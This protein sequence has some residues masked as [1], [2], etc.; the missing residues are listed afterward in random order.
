MSK[1]CL[2]ILAT[3]V[4][5][6]QMGCTTPNQ[7]RLN[8]AGDWR[9]LAEMTRRAAA[10]N[11]PAVRELLHWRGSIIAVG[12]TCYV[13]DVAN[14]WASQ[15]QLDADSEV[16]GLATQGTTAVALCGRAKQSWLLMADGEGS[17]QVIP[18]PTDQP[19]G[20]ANV[21]VA[22]SDGSIV[23]VTGDVCYR[24]G[25]GAWDIIRLAPL[26]DAVRFLA[27][28][29]GPLPDRVLLDDGNFLAAFDRGEWGG[30]LFRVNLDSREWEALLGLGMVGQS[31]NCPVTDL[32]RDRRGAIWALQSLGHSGL[33][34]CSV[35]CY[36]GGR[37]QI[38]GST[39]IAEGHKGHLPRVDGRAIAF[40]DE[41][42]P[43][44]LSGAQGVFR[45]DQGHWVR[46]TPDWGE[47]YIYVSALLIER[48]LLI[49]ATRD[50]GMLI[51]NQ[52]TH[53]AAYVPLRRAGPAQAQSVDRSPPHS[54]GDG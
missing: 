22:A 4:G 41:N 6:G 14:L 32:C 11:Q 2:V 40:D 50:G 1:G 36:E 12:D 15:L 38:L 25:T 9:P 47:E 42:R 8:K 35:W 43:Y 29:G 33:N 31:Q 16:L 39:G 21:R 48:G 7:G 34:E 44:V 46:V 30:G 3:I 13:V 17:G 49:I 20:A 45:L 54:E 18:V 26:P 28:H 19:L 37:W 23:L 52:G 5:G 51:Y 24:Y 53:L 27:Y 10:R